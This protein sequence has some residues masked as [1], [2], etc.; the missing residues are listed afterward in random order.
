MNAPADAR[1][2]ATPIARH[3]VNTPDEPESELHLNEFGLAAMEH[4]RRW[5]PR[6]YMR[7]SY[8]RGF[9]LA[10]GENARSE[11]ERRVAERLE[12]TVLSE[13][14]ARR[15]IQRTDLV[16]AVRDEVMQELILLPPE[17]NLARRYRN[18]QRRA[19]RAES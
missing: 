11:V 9:F 7:I 2:A 3:E 18:Y 14:P 5:R 12:K 10:I 19:A 13:H 16:S 15:F 6:A 1:P 17:R 8:P 4:W